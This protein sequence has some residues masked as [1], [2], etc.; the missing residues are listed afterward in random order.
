MPRQLPPSLRAL[1]R[2]S[3]PD[4]VDVP[5]GRF[6]FVRMFKHDFF[7][8]TAMY[9][10]DSG[11][12]VLKVGRKADFL[13][14]PLGWVGRMLTRRET[15]A[16]QRLQHLDSVPRYLG[17]WGGHG[18]LHEY[19]EGQPLSKHLVVP[20]DFFARLRAAVA[21]LH[22]QDMAYVDL[23]KPQNV[24][25]GD[26]GRPYL[27]DFQISWSLPR[28]FGGK[29]WPFRSILRSLQEADRYHLTKLQ[30][31][32][33]PDQLSSSEL[34]ESYRR[35]WYIRAHHWLTWPATALR[36]RTLERLDPNRADGERG[37]LP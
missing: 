30:R 36:R 17:T 8:A 27:I 6:H 4:V 11:R 13:G 25:L 21:Q 29:L 15:A 33:R 1:G 35:P 34:A 14:L 19:V 37:A 32:I 16:Y 24:I 2:V 23:E 18:F 12:A 9:E 28:R 10:G 31:R 5:T 7:A 20:D 26:D 3:L 22:A